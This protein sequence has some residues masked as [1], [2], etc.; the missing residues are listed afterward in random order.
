MRPV[1]PALLHLLGQVSR[2]RPA[3]QFALAARDPRKEQEARLA[4]FVRR[5]A[6]TEYGRK[7]WLAEARTPAEFVRRVP[8]MTAADLDPYVRRLM[9]GERNLLA[10]EAPIY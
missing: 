3:L 6:D 2:A 7:H 8:L 1:T 10:A 4:E 5:N 9:A